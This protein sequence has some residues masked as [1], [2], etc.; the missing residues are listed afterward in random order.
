MKTILLQVVKYLIFLAVGLVLL[1]LAFRSLDFNLLLHEIRN[2]RF[3]YPL[4]V[5]VPGLI[6]HGIRAA[7]W[8][9]M[10]RGLG[11]KTNFFST[12]HAVMIGYFANLAVPRLGEITRCTVLA[13]R[14]N[15]PL[16][17]LLGTV[18]AERA[19]DTITLV[20]IAFGVVIAQFGFLRSFL[21]SMIWSPLMGTLPASTG[22]IILA[23]GLTLVTLALFAILL[24]FSMPYI[25][26]IS[27]YGRMKELLLGLA[28]GLKILWRLR[29]KSAFLLQTLLMWFMYLL[30]TYIPFQAL[31]GTSHLS[32]LDGTTLLMM[33]S[34]AMIMPVPA[35]IGAYHWIVTKTLADVYSVAPETAA[36]YALISHAAQMFFV[37][38][39]G[40]VSLSILFLRKNIPLNEKIIKA[41]KKNPDA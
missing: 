29:Q 12:F 41:R 39:V 15:V 5:A 33:G 16:N 36:S 20:V 37:A 7:R 8:N 26:K 17:S 28:D 19:F 11:Y 40:L 24:K 23:V 9:I 27:F 35:G 18:I 6:A 14:Q 1:W 32:L 3:I 2:A 22:A 38:A 4:L 31:A 30:M 13:K 25:R 10:I 34:F 21:D